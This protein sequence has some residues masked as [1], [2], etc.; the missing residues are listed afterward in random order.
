MIH[1][2]EF[3]EQLLERRFDTDTISFQKKTLLV[4]SETYG[5]ILACVMYRAW[6]E[7]YQT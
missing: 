2:S 3:G 7:H 1:C 4:P 5:H 6:T